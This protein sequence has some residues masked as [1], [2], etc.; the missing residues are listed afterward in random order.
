MENKPFLTEK[1]KVALNVL[2]ESNAKIMTMDGTTAEDVIRERNRNKFNDAV[3]SY[4][5]KLN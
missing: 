4:V 2:G 5:E 3:D 1:E